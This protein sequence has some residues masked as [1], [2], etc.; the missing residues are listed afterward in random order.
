VLGTEAIGAPSPDIYD[1]LL[2][3]SAIDLGLAL[4]DR[5]GSRLVYVSLTDY[6][7]HKAAPG[8]EL[9]S[10]YC[11]A[12][13]DRL[14]RALDG[15]WVVGLVADH[16]MNAKTRPDGSP[17]VRYLSEALDAAGVH[18]A[19][20][21]LPIT[22][23]YVVHHGA[24]GSLAYVHLH[25]GSNLDVARGALAGLAGKSAA[26]HDLTSLGDTPLRSHGGLHEQAVPLVLCQPVRPVL[27]ERR[28][29]RG[30]DLFDLLLNGSVDPVAA[31]K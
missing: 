24:L 2:S 15:G 7:Q 27:A 29:L 14:G 21:V 23:P 30:F 3:A 10:L 1:P 31:A 5:L 16:G 11:S 17:E 6:V 19:T 12:L 4:A 18:G 28:D 20:V 25:E 26:E 22:D 9:A 8:S 13:D